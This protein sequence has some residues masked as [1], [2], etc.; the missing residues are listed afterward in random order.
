MT[1][2][3]RANG[4]TLIELLVVVAIIGMLSSIILASMTSARNK[5]NDS[6]VK[7]NLRTAA[8]Q[9]AL[10]QSDIGS[11]GTAVS[12]GSCPT[13]GTSMF[14]ASANVKQAIATA[15]N[16]GGGATRCATDGINFAISVQLRSNTNHWCIDSQSAIKEISNASWS[17]VACP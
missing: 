3:T 12:A 16:A 13:S 5:A 11:Y 2:H 14:V 15:A 10:Y 4:F 7:S 8:V 1:R 17:G 9:A 6:S